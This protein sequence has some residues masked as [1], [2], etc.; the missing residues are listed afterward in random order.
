MLDDSTTVLRELWSTVLDTTIKLD[1]LHVD[2]LLTLFFLVFF[3]G[4][5]LLTP[6]YDR[7]SQIFPLVVGIPGFLVT[8]SLLL[9]QLSDLRQLHGQHD[10]DDPK[11]E[12]RARV[13]RAILITGWVLLLFFLLTIVGFTIGS[14]LFL[15][16]F[17]RHVA[18]LGWKQ[19]LLYSIGIWIPTMFLF[20]VV[21]N[22]P[23]PQGIIDV[24]L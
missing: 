16:L 13:E 21:L 22:V 20:D 15:L 12:V 7:S 5:L 17:Y 9:T 23:L 3:A 24:I 10:R 11:E 14:L 6:E 19:T 2:L 1:R 4:L 8:L 18:E